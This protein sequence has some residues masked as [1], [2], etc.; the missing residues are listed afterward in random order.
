MADL[1]S[2]G[3]EVRLYSCSSARLTPLLD[4][5]G[6]KMWAL[7]GEA[8]VKVPLITDDLGPRNR[9]GHACRAHLGTG[10]ET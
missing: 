3:F 10:N 1:S 5:G 2:R 6:N 4:R 9:R 8:F 7:A